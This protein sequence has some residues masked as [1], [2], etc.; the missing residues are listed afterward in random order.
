MSAGRLRAAALRARA[1]TSSHWWAR[2]KQH[3]PA[4]FAPPLSAHTR[5]LRPVR[6]RLMRLSMLRPTP[7]VGDRGGAW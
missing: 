5:P 7:P 1:V 4:I 3:S 6:I 2:A